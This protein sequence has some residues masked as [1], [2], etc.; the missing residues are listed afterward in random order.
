MPLSSNNLRRSARVNISLRSKKIM[1][2]MFPAWR[3]LAYNKH[4]D[5]IGHHKVNKWVLFNI[6]INHD[7]Q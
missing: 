7:W 2:L 6:S 5:G 4:V 3:S 1:S